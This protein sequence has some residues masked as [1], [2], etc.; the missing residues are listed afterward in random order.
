MIK[1]QTD[2][3]IDT[4]DRDKLLSLFK[5]NVASICNNNEFKKHNTGVY[6]TDIPTNPL[7]DLAT[8]DYENAEERGYV[9]FDIL[10]VSLYKDI[11][12]EQH[13]DSLLNKEPLWD[14][15]GH[16]EFA[17]NLFHVGEHSQILQK[18]KPTTIEQLAAVLAIIRPSKRY[19]L[20]CDWNKIMQEVWTKPTDGAYYFKK[21]H[22][23]A[24]AHA[25]VVQMNLIC[26]Q[27]QQ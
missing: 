18:L 9:K 21:A 12:D 4:G 17:E 11:K 1:V 6:F 5:Y 15:L 24:Y 3:D 27:L 13:L 16:K 19:L 22:A 23:I 8:I 20:D 25:I 7:T 14:L 26:E 2:I 10:N